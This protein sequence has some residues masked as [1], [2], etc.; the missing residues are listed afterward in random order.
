MNEKIGR[1]LREPIYLNNL[2]IYFFLI[3][4]AYTKFYPAASGNL[5]NS[6]FLFGWLARL[7]QNA[8]ADTIIDY[9]IQGMKL[10]RLMN[11]YCPRPPR[12]PLPV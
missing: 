9:K 10:C 6:P 5:A 7:V 3:Y 12:P 4:Q 2:K 8:V 1:H 11:S